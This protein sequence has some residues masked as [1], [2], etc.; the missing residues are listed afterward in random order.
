MITVFSGQWLALM[1][2]TPGKAMWKVE[3]ILRTLTLWE[4]WICTQKRRRLVMANQCTKVQNAGEAWFPLHSF[5]FQSGAGLHHPVTS[6]WVWLWGST[7]RDWNV[8]I[9]VGEGFIIIDIPWTP[10]FQAAGRHWLQALS[11]WVPGTTSCL[12]SLAGRWLSDV[13]HPRAYH[14]SLLIFYVV[15]VQPLSRVWLCDPWTAAS[16]ALLSST[17]SQSLLRLMSF[18]SVMPSKHLILCR[19]L[20]LLPSIFASIRVFS[21]E[22]VLHNFS[23][24][25][26]PSNEYSE[27]ISFRMD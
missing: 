9:G 12:F 16:Q 2:S 4:N 7:S 5:P 15:V 26:S 22:S 25:I 3:E 14:P 17:I 6:D 11:C 13:A 10:P 27:L 21:S 19:P 23:F 8:G 24:S 18:E 20:L 1:G